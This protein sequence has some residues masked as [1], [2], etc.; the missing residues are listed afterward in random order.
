MGLSR[1]KGQPVKAS[2]GGGDAS[3][4]H[5]GHLSSAHPC[6]GYLSHMGI[7]IMSPTCRE[8]IACLVILPKILLI[9]TSLKNNNQ[10]IISTWFYISKGISSNHII[11]SPP[12]NFLTNKAHNTGKLL[13][14]HSSNIF[15]RRF[16]AVRRNRAFIEI[17]TILSQFPPLT[18]PNM[19][20]NPTP[21]QGIRSHPSK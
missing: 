10:E 20:V 17:W 8:R 12:S 13:I 19:K 3:P 16:G 9:P 6:I 7:R 14:Q 5:Y 4:Q 1:R 11:S 18:P 15:N 21:N 2:R